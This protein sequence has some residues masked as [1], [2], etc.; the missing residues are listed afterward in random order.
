M[1][2]NFISPDIYTDFSGFAKQKAEARDHSPAAL[3]KVAKQFEAVFVQMVMKSMREASLGDGIFDNDKSNFYRDMYDKQLSVHLSRDSHLGFAGLIMR[4]IGG[5]NHTHEGTSQGRRLDD[6]RA[7]PAG[8]VASNNHPKTLAKTV[9]SISIK[10]GANQISGENKRF[11]SQK[12]FVESLRPDAFR[13]ARQLG[14]HPGVLLAQAALESG[15][16]NQ[17][18]KHQSGQDS[19]NLFGI[20]ADSRWKGPSAVVPT[21]EY[22]GGIAR[23]QQ[24]RFRSYQRF[25][26]SF[27][28]YVHFI[29]NNPRYS[30]ALASAADPRKYIEALQNAGYATDPAY[31]KKVMNIF[32]QKGFADLVSD[33]S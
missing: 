2:S 10:S 8:V 29:K 15:W 20:K 19:Y 24:A 16:G 32:D 18:I 22:E 4:Q 3:E 23:K 26:D 17:S 6:Y 28:D 25:A 33:R 9:P 21:L 7:H 13:A 14:V 30:E 1:A 12:E 27:Q 11:A 5:G 31:A